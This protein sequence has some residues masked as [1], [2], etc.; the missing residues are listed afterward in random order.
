MR[1]NEVLWKQRTVPEVLIVVDHCPAIILHITARPPG[2]QRLARI[3]EKGERKGLVFIGSEA[4]DVIGRGA[5]G[6]VM[7]ERFPQILSMRSADARRT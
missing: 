6:S 3:V 4:H 1:D 5:R 2:G 7:R